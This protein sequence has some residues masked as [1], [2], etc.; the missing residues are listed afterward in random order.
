MKRKE[1]REMGLPSFFDPDGHFYVCLGRK[2]LQAM[3]SQCSRKN[4]LDENLLVVLD[5]L[6]KQVLEAERGLQ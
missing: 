6:E 1:K 3:I 2:E 5:T 4:T